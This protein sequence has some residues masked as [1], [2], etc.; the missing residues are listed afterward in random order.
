MFSKIAIICEGEKTEPRLFDNIKEN[1]FKGKQFTLICLPA[2]MNIHMLAK[3]IKDDGYLDIIE[4]I[5]ERNKTAAKMLD[6]YTKDDFEGVYLFFD[7]DPQDI[8]NYS[9]ENLNMMLSVFDNETVNGKLYISY[10]MVEAIR[11]LKF[12]DNCNRRCTHDICG[13]RHYKTVVSDMTE[14][15]DFKSYDDNKWKPILQHAVKKANCIVFEDNLENCGKLYTIPDREVFINRISQKEIYW[16]QQ[17]KFISN[18]KVAILSSV[19]L[20]L[21]EYMKPSFWKSFVSK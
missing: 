21:L 7:L 10:P 5:R 2:A 20:F 12:N 1:F 18:G 15:T 13:G 3:C 17:R 14:F 11:D 8:G 19:P 6:G 16:A 4:V 9:E